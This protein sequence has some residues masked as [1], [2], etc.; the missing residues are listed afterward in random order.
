MEE[1]DRIFYDFLGN[2][3][4]TP[5]EIAGMIVRYCESG[6]SKPTPFTFLKWVN[7]PSKLSQ[8]DAFE[9]AL[10]IIKELELRLPFE[11]QEIERMRNH[12]FHAGKKDA[13]MITEW[14]ML[15]KINRISNQAYLE[16]FQELEDP[17]YFSCRLTPKAR[18]RGKGTVPDYSG[19]RR[20]L[21]LEE[22]LR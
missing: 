17:V 8:P 4:K 9:V 2:W 16:E 18:Y 22:G 1:C 11:E 15:H 7:Y 19:F 14:A 10:R 13:L 5:E 6:D 3:E 20:G 21:Y 12:F